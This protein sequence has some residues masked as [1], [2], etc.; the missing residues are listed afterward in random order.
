[1]YSIVF[2]ISILILI[3]FVF[4]IIYSIPLEV[5]EFTIF[6]EKIDESFYGKKILQISDLHC[7]SFGDNN[8]QLIEEIDR[9]NPDVIFVTGDMID[10]D[11]KDYN[12]VLYLLE[13]ISNKYKVFY[14]TGNHEHKALLKKYKKEYLIYFNRLK[15]LNVNRLNNRKIVVDS[16][17]NVVKSLPIITSKHR[18]IDGIED[19]INKNKEGHYINIYSLILPFN[20]YRYLLSNRNVETVDYDYIVNKLGYL[21]SN[22]YNILLSHNP[23]YFDDYVKWRVD[24]IFSGHVHGGIIRLPFVGG[25][26]SPDRTF[27]PKY[28]SGKY[29]KNGTTMFVS[30]GLGGS[31]IGFRLYNK[32]ELLVVKFEGPKTI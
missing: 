21:D 30:R 5:R 8:K 6:S 7:K 24:L 4:G 25:I 12:S 16:S 20:T 18:H 19:K 28:S 23:L 3:F 15:K 27:F 26:L 9:Q 29:S 31:A 1:M 2:V 11:N 13:Y 14:I 32:P 22:E 17:F 10:G